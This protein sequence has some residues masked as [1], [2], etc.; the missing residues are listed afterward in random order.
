M[1]GVYFDW[2]EEHGG[3]HDLG[4]IAEEVGNYVP[5]VVS[6]EQNSEFATGMD[7]GMMNPILLQAIKEQQIL[8]QRQQSQIDELLEK[9]SL[10]EEK[11]SK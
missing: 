7:Y 5:E 11:L 3:S 2:D 9:L 6:Y 4:F 1:R 10:I 8:I